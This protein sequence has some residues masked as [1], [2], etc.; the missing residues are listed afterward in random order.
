MV[1]SLLNYLESYLSFF[2]EFNYSFLKVCGGVVV[3]V[4]FSFFGC[5]YFLIGVFKIG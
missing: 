4:S 3:V 1:K 2:S 5:F